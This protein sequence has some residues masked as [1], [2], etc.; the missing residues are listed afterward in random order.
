MVEYDTIL[1][2]DFK[3]LNEKYGLDYGDEK[4]VYPSEETASASA[5]A[6]T[7]RPS[8]DDIYATY[9]LAWTKVAR[10]KGKTPPSMDEVMKGISI[11]DWEVAIRDVFGWDEYSAQEIYD[12]VVEYDTILQTDIKTMYAKYGLD[13]G[14]EGT[15]S[16]N[17]YPELVLQE[18]VTDWL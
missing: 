6:A 9:T 8:K 7:P 12:I 11:R 2:A 13:Y 4:D 10:E 1:Q 15:E 14:N 3:R 16:W 18:G 17:K 5:T